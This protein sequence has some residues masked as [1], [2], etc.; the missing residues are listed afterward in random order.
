M[1]FVDRAG[2]VEVFAFLAWDVDR[3]DSGDG[4]VVAFEA[5]PAPAS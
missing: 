2:P 4:M 1:L 3:D 5:H